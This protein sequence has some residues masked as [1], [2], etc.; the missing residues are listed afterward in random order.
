M[1]KT[2]R[3]LE[4]DDVT[5]S[6]S[7]RCV[8]EKKRFAWNFFFQRSRVLWYYWANMATQKLE[9]ASWSHTLL[10]DEKAELTR[11]APTEQ[12][13]K[14]SFRHWFRVLSPF[15]AT[16]EDSCNLKFQESA[17]WGGMPRRGITI[18]SPC[19]LTY[20]N[21]L[22]E[23]SDRPGYPR[24]QARLGDHQTTSLWRGCLE[25]GPTPL[26]L[27]PKYKVFFEIWPILASLGRAKQR[28][29]GALWLTESATTMKTW[30]SIDEIAK[31]L[32]DWITVW[33]FQ[34]TWYWEVQGNK[35][36]LVLRHPDLVPD[37]PFLEELALSPVHPAEVDTTRELNETAVLKR[38]QALCHQWNVSDN[39]DYASMVSA[40]LVPPPPADCNQPVSWRTNTQFRILAMRHHCIQARAASSSFATALFEALSK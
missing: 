15:L 36:R 6:R 27:T 32:N 34:Q 16:G 35:S 25:W 13:F 28:G 21:K 20:T 3:K 2:N 7:E 31:H 18:P 17:M 37:Y 14:G 5:F 8:K 38:I 11:S 30:P 33:G 1:P 10:G 39:P 23:E 12:E 9:I 26:Q 22:A 29:R 40:K 19:V 24:A 4:Q